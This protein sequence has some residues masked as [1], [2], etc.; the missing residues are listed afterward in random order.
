MHHLF[1]RLFSTV[2]RSIAPTYS[3]TQLS[4]LFYMQSSLSAARDKK[5]DFTPRTGGNRYRVLDSSE[6]SIDKASLAVA[7]GVGTEAAGQE[8]TAASAAKGA[9][10]KAE[11]ES[12][13]ETTI[14]GRNKMKSAGGQGGGNLDFL[15]ARALQGATLQHQHQ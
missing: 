12:K 13:Q 8:A 9:G 3:A 14:A 1:L 15:L 10:E 2:T 4:S 11:P 6:N 7:A 5:T